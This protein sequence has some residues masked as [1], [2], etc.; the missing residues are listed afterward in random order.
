[1]KSLVYRLINRLIGIFETYS[2]L[3]KCSEAKNIKYLNLALSN[4]DGDFSFSDKESHD[5]NSIVDG[6]SY[7]G[8]TVIVKVSSSDNVISNNIASVPNFIKIDVEGFEYFVLLG[9]KSLLLNSYL[10]S[11][12][13]EV[14]FSKLDQLGLPKASED[15]SKLLIDSGF[16]LTWIDPSHL[17]AHREI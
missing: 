4:E 7:E 16:K 14:H 12:L 15:I 8:D 13:I 6:A 1:M 17:F 11:I 3:L 2:K 10:T 5:V 9:M